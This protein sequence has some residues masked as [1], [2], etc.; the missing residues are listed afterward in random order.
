M[1]QRRCQS[2]INGLKTSKRKKTPLTQELSRV[3]M[4]LKWFL[5]FDRRFII[6]NLHLLCLCFTGN[7]F[8]AQHCERVVIKCL[9]FVSFY[10]H[11]A[12]VLFAKHSCVLK[13]TAAATK[14]YRLVLCVNCPHESCNMAKSIMLG[15]KM[16]SLNASMVFFDLS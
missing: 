7:E 14:L 3:I 10:H 5:S 12:F 16:K 2:G 9:R 8:F 4:R 13:T 6:V 1:T 15:I 11:R